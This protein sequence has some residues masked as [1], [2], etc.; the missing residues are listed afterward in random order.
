MNND[1]EEPHPNN[2]LST[3]PDPIFN[4]EMQDFEV[5]KADYPEKRGTKLSRERTNN[6]LNPH[7]ASTPGLHPWPHW[8]E[9]SSLTTL[10]FMNRAP[11]ADISFES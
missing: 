11:A 3:T 5:K 7:M 1:L 6:K 8:W 2:G 4:L 10:V 9:A